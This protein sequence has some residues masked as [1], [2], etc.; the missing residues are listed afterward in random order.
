MKLRSGKILHKMNI[1]A[2]E[3][4]PAFMIKEGKKHAKEAK[5]EVKK[6]AE[7]NIY[8]TYLNKE[9]GQHVHLMATTRNI[10]KHLIRC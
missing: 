4:I 1:N 10:P 8:V 3:F 7:A 2:K 5:T 6:T 9:S